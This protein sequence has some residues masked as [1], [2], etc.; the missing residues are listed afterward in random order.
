IPG[1]RFH[2]GGRLRFGPDGMLYVGTGDGQ[3]PDR[4]QDTTSPNG[5]ILRLTPDGRVPED[6]PWPPS[7]AYVKGLRNVEAFDFDANGMLYIAD[8]GP[9]G[10]LDRTGHDE[11]DVA[12]R[13]DN[14]GWP[15]IYGCSTAPSMVA[16]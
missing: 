14:L 13:G 6:N 1:S 10:E 16:P 15:A 8:H 7:P 9:S 4:S 3:R 11:I 2:D 5:K 12:R